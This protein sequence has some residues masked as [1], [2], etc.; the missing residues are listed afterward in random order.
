MDRISE[1]QR[2]A[3]NKTSDA[4]L[5]AKLVQAGFQARDVEVLERPKLIE[6]M[7]ALTAEENESVTGAVAEVTR[8]DFEE[9]EDVDDAKGT[10]VAL[11][12]LDKRQLMLREREMEERRQHRLL[13]ER[14]LEQEK[15][16]KEKELLLKEKEMEFVRE[17]SRRETEWKENPANKLTLWGTHCEIQ[18]RVCL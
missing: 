3:I 1:Q 15:V 13:E 5:R 12:S 10:V 14:R 9:T 8:T 17:K 6:M 4:H 16:L 2:A 18:S 7:L 11:M